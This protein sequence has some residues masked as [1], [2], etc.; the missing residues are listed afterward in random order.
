ML[1]TGIKVVEVIP[2]AVNTDLGGI[3][4]HDTGANLDAYCD[5]VLAKLLDNQLEIT[6][7]FSQ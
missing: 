5:D 3:G 7:G 1:Q 4:L 6:Y 2:P